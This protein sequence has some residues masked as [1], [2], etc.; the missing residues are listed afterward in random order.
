MAEDC[1]CPECGSTNIW[2]DN[3]SWGCKDCRFIRISTWL[4]TPYVE[5][6]IGGLGD[7]N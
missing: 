4:N 3:A 1:R 7:A 5:P 2:D 6:K